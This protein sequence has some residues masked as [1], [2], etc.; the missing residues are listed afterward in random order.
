MTFPATNYKLTNISI[1]DIKVVP[2]YIESIHIYEGLTFPALTG[3]LYLKDWDGLLEIQ[4]I[5]AGDSIKISFVSETDITREFTFRGILTGSFNNVVSTEHTAPIITL[6]FCSEW[7][8]KA[9]TKQI[10]KAWKN[11]YVSEIIEDILVNECG[12][13]FGGF[14][15]ENTVK[16]ER[17]VSPFWTP[18]HIIKYLL[19]FCRTSDNKAGFLLYEDLYSQTPICMTLDYLYAENWGTH[20]S[21]IIANSQNIIYEGNLRYLWVENQFNILRHLNQ[22]VYKTEYNGFDFDR[23]THLNISSTIKDV[24]GEHLTNYLPLKTDFAT[25]EFMSR[26]Q[27]MRYL[28]TSNL[29][30]ENDILKLIENQKDN[31]FVGLYSDLIKLN[32]LLPGATNRSVGQLVKVNFPSVNSNS[33]ETARN[34]Q[35]EGKYLIRDIQHILTNDVFQQAITV[36]SDGLYNTDRTD[37]VNW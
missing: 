24:K 5:F 6:H 11:K 31:R 37:L 1:G 7:W 3:K 33:D 17:F 10:S 28:Q 25:D 13:D 32:F 27:T 18:A 9:I 8:F 15:P 23:L 26:K 36:V 4:E 21:E 20:P 19:D 35:L 16:L 22:G 29:T 30:N 12:A 34:K 14:Y 2:Q